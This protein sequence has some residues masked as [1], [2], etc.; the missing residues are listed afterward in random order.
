MAANEIGPA[1]DARGHRRA[2]GLDG[3]PAEGRGLRAALTSPRRSRGSRRA[4]TIASRLQEI[5]S[6]PPPLSSRLK[7]KNAMAAATS[8]GFGRLLVYLKYNFNYRFFVS[9]KRRNYNAG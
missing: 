1:H 5:D 6:A 8:H 9:S 7:S 2:H 4:D 3:R